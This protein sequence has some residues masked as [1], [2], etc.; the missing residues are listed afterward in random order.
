MRGRLMKLRLEAGYKTQVAFVAELDRLSAGITLRRYRSM[1]QG[2]G[3]FT[4]IELAKIADVLKIEL[5][6]LIE[7]K[8]PH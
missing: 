1:E 7:T 8:N 5:S 2:K 4:T 3:K 6:E